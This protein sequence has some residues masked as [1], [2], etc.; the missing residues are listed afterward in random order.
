MHLTSARLTSACLTSACLAIVCLSSVVGCDARS[1]SAGGDDGGRSG[2]DQPCTGAPK[3]ELDGERLVFDDASQIAGEVVTMGCCDGA[4]VRANGRRSNG[5]A[6]EIY[7]A[8]AAVPAGDGRGVELPTTLDL[9]EAATRG[10]RIWLNHASCGD[11][12][13]CEPRGSYKLSGTA[14]I[15][16]TAF[17]RPLSLSVCARGVLDESSSDAGAP[18]VI[19]L[20]VDDLAVPGVP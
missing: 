6:V 10:W 18:Q 13:R 8:L 1:V 20:Y 14:E 11:P 17:Y 2:V 16:G 15:N 9:E 19:T 5:A 3:I 4:A 7:F 12:G